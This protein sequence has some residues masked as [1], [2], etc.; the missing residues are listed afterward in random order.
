MKINRRI[1]I[2]SGTAAAAA[3]AFAP[4]N[5]VR[6][7]QKLRPMQIVLGT[8]PQFTNVIIGLTKGFYEK[9]GL[10]VDIR[11]FTSGSAA[12]QAFRAGNGDVVVSGDLPS[13][14]LWVNGDGIG[15]C[16]QA[17]YD[18][19][20]IV[21]RDSIKSPADMRGKKIGVLF[22]STSEYF[23]GKYLA[24]GGMTIKDIQAINLT[25]A[26]MVTGL[27]RGDIDGFVLWEPFGWKATETIKGVHI[28]TTAGPYFQE[29]EACTTNRKYAET[30][31]A[32]LVAFLKGLDAAGKW[33]PGHVDEA[34]QSVADALRTQDVALVKRMVSVINYDI[35]YTPKFR[36]DM[37]ELAG[38][39]K[40]KIDWNTMFDPR[41][42]R[43]ANRS[44]VS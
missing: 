35:S 8:T 22:G 37:D 32:E 36:K 7:Q 24:G 44:F 20:M 13:L 27:D 26:E 18:L 30:H 23:I 15:L 5:I 28:L 10:P 2:A 38:F 41:F 29:W 9:E 12:T 14:R 21:T 34:S 25:P 31:Q 40:N 16:P 4:F 3:A 33:I 42:L 17:H 11:Y 19:S 6:A 43:L 1:A 39:L